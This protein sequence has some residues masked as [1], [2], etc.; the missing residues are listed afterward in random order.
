MQG[1]FEPLQMAKNE[2][3]NFSEKEKH[4]F[5]EFL[6]ELLQVEKYREDRKKLLD[7]MFW[8]Y[9]NYNI[10]LFEDRDTKIY[11]YIT[12]KRN[13]PNSF[14]GSTMGFNKTTMDNKYLDILSKFKLGKKPAIPSPNNC[15]EFEKLKLLIIK[16]YEMR[17]KK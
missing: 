7:V 13:Y 14:L 5:K 17:N 11:K 8:E 10:H 2:N 16:L 4:I 12:D 6:S 3:E 15:I 1:F 9:A